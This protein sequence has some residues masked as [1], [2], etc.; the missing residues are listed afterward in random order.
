[1]KTDFCSLIQSGPFL[2]AHLL[3]NSD[4]SLIVSEIC[5]RNQI[6]E[7]QLQITTNNNNTVLEVHALAQASSQ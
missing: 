5:K 2:S 3:M 6:D 1:M 7:L 4:T